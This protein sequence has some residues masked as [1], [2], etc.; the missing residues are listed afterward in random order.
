MVLA[1]GTRM[2]TESECGGMDDEGDY[3][4]NGSEEDER[5]NSNDRT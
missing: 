1:E 3:E 2:W 5:R 4:R